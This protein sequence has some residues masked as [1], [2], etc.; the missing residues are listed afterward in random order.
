MRKI[1]HTLLLLGMS[2]TSWSQTVTT[3][4]EGSPDDAITMDGNGNIYVTGF[5]SG[6]VYQYTSAGVMTEFLNG[7]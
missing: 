2:I 3:I 7:L 6:S 4:V 1:T 5:D